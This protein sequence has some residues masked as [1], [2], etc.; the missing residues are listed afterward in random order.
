MRGSNSAL[1]A[2]WFLDASSPGDGASQDGV[3]F[4]YERHYFMDGLLARDAE[5]E[6]CGEIAKG[7]CDM[8][9]VQCHADLLFRYDVAA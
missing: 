9:L 1:P 7:K 4:F 5:A 2:T 6:L 3:V 8:W